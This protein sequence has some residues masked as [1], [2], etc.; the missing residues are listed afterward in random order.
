MDISG[1]EKRFLEDIKNHEIK[2]QINQGLHKTIKSTYHGKTWHNWFYVVGSPGSI[3]IYGDNGSLA[4]ERVEDMFS[5]IKQNQND[6]NYL[7]SKVPQDF[8]TK[9]YNSELVDKF[10]DNL[11]E[12]MNPSAA[13]SIKPKLRELDYSLDSSEICR[14]L[15]YKHGFI[16]FPSFEEYSFS[17]LW[18]FCAIKWTVNQYYKIINN[19]QN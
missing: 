19:E 14:F 7:L 6:H 17:T 3:Y 2:I 16:D 8:K 15:F 4:M 9:V 11:E 13:K 1:V 10:I 18:N 5:F 12:Y